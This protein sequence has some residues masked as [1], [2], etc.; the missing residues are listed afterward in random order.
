MALRLEI[1]SENINSRHG[2][3]WEINSQEAWVFFKNQNGQ[4]NDYPEK[5][6]INLQRDAKGNVTPYEIGTYSWDVEASL[7]IGQYN[8]ARLGRFTLQKLGTPAKQ[9]A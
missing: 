6:T 4:L 5:I 8:S 9:A 1:K 3:D 7:Y 2:N